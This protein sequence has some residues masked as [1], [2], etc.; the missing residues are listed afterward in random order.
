[1]ADVIY[2]WIEKCSCCGC[3]AKFI[4]WSC[5]CVTVEILDESET[6]WCSDCD[7]FSSR[8]ESCGKSGWPSD[9]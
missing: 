6:G 5:G 3:R 4:K 9:D 1:M 8:K 7:N 2:T